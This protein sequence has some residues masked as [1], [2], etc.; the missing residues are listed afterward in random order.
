MITVS[1]I[2]VLKWQLKDAINYKWSECGRCFNELTGKEIK[3]ILNGRSV[4]YCIKGKFQSVNTL[5]S[6]LE[7]IPKQDCPF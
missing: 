1:N 7:L 6:Q 5:R 3:K 2:Y 4:G